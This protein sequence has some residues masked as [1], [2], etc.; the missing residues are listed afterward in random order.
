MTK[1][2]VLA[3]ILF[4]SYIN[5]S[6]GNDV[7]I[8]FKVEDEI[9]TN[10]DIINEINY[11]ISLNQ[12]LESL[13]IDSLN[14]L[15]SKSLIKE[16]I[17]FLQLK[18]FFDLERE[19]EDIN[20]IIYRNLFSTLNLNSKD[21]LKNYFLKYNLDFDDILYKY[22][23]EILWNKLIYDKY[24][25]KVQI[26]KK[27]LRKQISNEIANREIIEEYFIREIMFNVNSNEN[28]DQKF[29]DIIN[30]I[31]DKGFSVAANIFSLSPSSKNGGQIGWIK[32]T[33][34]SKKILSNIS[35]LNIGDITDP[36][37]VSG[38]YLII[39]LENKRDTQVKVNLENELKLLVNKETDRQL[40]QYS[41]IF[42]NRIKKS[43]IINEI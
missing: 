4:F 10:Q 34:L 9:I 13:P 22:K 1:K 11:L 28:F 14:Q 15:A 16:K 43:I 2:L 3:I 21:E 30:T 42:F 26:D 33:Q 25:A 5:L 31:N 32:K 35:T 20:R 37:E 40:N 23:I 24:I 41:T 18:N 27:K 7:L 38:G 12:D 8:K 6:I 36:M 19:D 39:N 17:K 29:E